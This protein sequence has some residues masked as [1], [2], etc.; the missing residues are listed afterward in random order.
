M[1]IY[2]KVTC[3]FILFMVHLLALSESDILLCWVIE[4]REDGE[5]IIFGQV[6]RI[7]AFA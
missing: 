1:H 3:F 5:G 4:C 7:L 2:S 6:H